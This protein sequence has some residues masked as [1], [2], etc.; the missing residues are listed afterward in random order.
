[1]QC[2]SAYVLPMSSFG[3]SGGLEFSFMTYCK[4]NAER[5]AKLKSL[6]AL[7]ILTVEPIVWQRVIKKMPWSDALEVESPRWLKKYR[8]SPVCHYSSLLKSIKKASNPIILNIILY[9]IINCAISSGR[10]TVGVWHEN[11][12]FAKD[13]PRKNRSNLSRALRTL[14]LSLCPCHVQSHYTAAREHYTPQPSI[15]N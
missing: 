1:M 10:Q 3:A 14:S 12:S 8:A 9:I 11:T 7:V 5:S 2:V 4:K 15:M 6:K 13:E